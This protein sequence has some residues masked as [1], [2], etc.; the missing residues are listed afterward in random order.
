LAEYGETPWSQIVS[1]EAS[2]AGRRYL[3]AFNAAQLADVRDY[4]APLDIP[5]G[6]PVY[7]A[8]KVRRGIG[9]FNEIIINDNRNRYKQFDL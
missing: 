8:M 4:S 7:E 5:T 2:A 9:A 3:I 6:R 1:C